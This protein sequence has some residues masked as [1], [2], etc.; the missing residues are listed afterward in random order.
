[1]SGSRVP[2]VTIIIATYNKRATLNY[3]IESVLW[4]T[5]TDFE[6]WVVGDACTDDSESLVASFDDPRLHW[7][8]LPENSGYQSA[9]N[10]EGLRRAK[11]EYIA[12][13][14]HD[15]IWLPNHLQVLVDSIKQNQADFVYSIMEWVRKDSSIADIPNYPDAP[16]PP[17]ASAT[18]HRRDVVDRIGY[19][20]APYET[21]A[22]PRVDF[23]RQAQF[24]E[25]SFAIAPFLTVL[26]FN[27]NEAG[28]AFASQHAEYMQRIAQEPNFAEQE[29]AK[30]LIKAY[31]QIEGPLSWN[32]TRFQ[33]L[34]GIRMSLAKRRIE[35]ERLMP[36]LSAGQRIAVW[37]KRH[38]LDSK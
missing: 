6:C 33:L 27:R 34:Q 26:K 10:N 21:Y 1:M 3:A 15:D 7:Y 2:N 22:F 36:W 8:N 14:N 32:R 4:Q 23:F 20:K 19:W 5:F 38:G 29:L 13:L 35:P 18:L 12:Y 28:Y 11:G 30:L 16:R 25:M 17:E 24:A 31:W 37:R 9:P